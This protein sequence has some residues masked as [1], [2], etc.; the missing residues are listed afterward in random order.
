MLH[1]ASSVQG[2]ALAIRN[3]ITTGRINASEDIHGRM[4]EWLI[5]PPWKGGIRK[6]RIEGSNPSPSARIAY[7]DELSSHQGARSG[8]RIT[9][10]TS[11]SQADDEGSTPFARSRRKTSSPTERSAGLFRFRA[12]KTDV[13]RGYNFLASCFFFL[14]TGE[15]MAARNRLI[16]LD[17]ETTGLNAK[18][19]DRIIENG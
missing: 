1:S 6:F 17:T 15:L 3:P 19:G 12:T 9:A 11:A 14:S 4:A 13:L 16:T 10:I 8:R 2:T 18:G 7:L 5:V